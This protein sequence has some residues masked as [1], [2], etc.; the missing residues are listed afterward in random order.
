M[1]ITGLVLGMA[2]SLAVPTIASAQMAGEIY[3]GVAIEG[4][5]D[6]GGV[7]FDLDSGGAF[8]IGAYYTGF[9]PIE[10]G[11][12]I[13]GTSRDYSGYQSALKSQSVMINGRYVFPLAGATDAYVGLGVGAIKVKYDG[14][15]QFP[16]FTGDDTV[17]GGQVAVGARYAFGA[18][19]GFGE[20]RYQTAFDDADIQGE[21][22]KYNSMSAL[23]GLRFSF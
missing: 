2:V 8:G 7:N 3:G 12:D 20:L 17:A 21:A 23:V 13:M 1:N 15:N 5:A 10:V 18:A 6:Y 22:V 9:A 14:A 19:I 4:D 16:A 11:L